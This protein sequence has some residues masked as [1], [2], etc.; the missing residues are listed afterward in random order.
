[1]DDCLAIPHD[2]I[3]VLKQLDNFFQMKTGSIGD[4]DIYLGAKLREVTLNDGVTCWSMSSAMYIKNA[5]R[6]VEEYIEEHRDGMKLKKKAS[7]SW[8]SN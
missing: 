1:M 4:P 5:I 2:A 8:P 3:S 6:N 7:L